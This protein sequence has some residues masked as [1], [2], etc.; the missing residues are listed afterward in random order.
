MRRHLL[1]RSFLIAWCAIPLLL[2]VVLILSA[3]GFAGAAEGNEFAIKP[4]LKATFWSLVVGFGGAFLAF[5]WMLIPALVAVR[6]E[7]G[8]RRKFLVISA[9]LPLFV[10]PAVVS[11]AAVRLLG[12]QGFITDFIYEMVFPDTAETVMRVAPVFSM[13]GVALTLAWAYSPIG[14]LVNWSVLKRIDPL[15]EEAA[16]LDTNPVSVLL[17]ITLPG[18]K[19]GLLLGLSL[20]F[21]LAFTD[22]NVPESLRSQPVLSA[23][24]YTQFGVYYDGRAAALSAIMLAV[25]AALALGA[26]GRIFGATRHS[27]DVTEEAGVHK[28]RPVPHSAGIVLIRIVG[29]FLAVAPT[30]ALLGIL[31]YTAIGPDG[32]W[33]TIKVTWG[34]AHSEFVY[35]I[36]LSTA[37]AV[38]CLIVGSALGGVLSQLQRPTFL[39]LVLLCGFI[40]PGPIVGVAMKVILLPPVGLLPGPIDQALVWADGTPIPLIFA[41]VLR[42]A[43]LVAILIEYQLRS[44][45]PELRDAASIEGGWLSALRTW[46]L[47]AILPALLAA[48]V[49]VFA[50]TLG[51]GGAAILLIPPG[52][53]TLSVRLLTLMHYAPTSQVSALCLFMATPALVAVPFVL[54]FADSKLEKGT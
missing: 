19:R 54:G 28:F 51:E 2:C 42:F 25:I 20:L 35:T 15:P 52:T 12:A 30:L 45:A 27:D 29:W 36:L 46:A 5:L 32:F 48:G 22:F 8:W 9:S 11:V 18:N 33:E 37:T 21:L 17:K 47:P 38:T 4:V 10:S 14:F 26:I 43:P 7:T 23:F 34:S 40:F 39:R 24:V 49:G 50:L 31:V 44:V 16:R 41:W 6:I 3:T 1:S 13:W 53:T